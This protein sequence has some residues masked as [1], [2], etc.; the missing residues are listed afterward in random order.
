MGLACAVAAPLSSRLVA[1]TGASAPADSGGVPSS[2]SSLSVWLAGA[3]AA[4]AATGTAGG[5][6]PRDCGVTAVTGAGSA[7]LRSG[8]WGTGSGVAATVSTSTSPPAG[9]PKVGELPGVAGTRGGAS[10]SSLSSLD[11]AAAA[12]S[13]VLRPDAADPTLLVGDVTWRRAGLPRGD[14]CWARRAS[15]LCSSVAARV[16]ELAALLRCV[17]VDLAR[18]TSGTTFSSNAWDCAFIRASTADVR[19]SDDSTGST[20][21]TVISSLRLEAP[22]CSSATNSRAVARGSAMKASS[23]TLKSLVRA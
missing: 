2:S 10:G 23:R 8:V 1:T 6:A 17:P 14:P 7:A 5:A 12:A 20:V 3:A 4:T 22:A 21:S 18:C 19:S 13:A 9:A 16:A 15:S 11:T